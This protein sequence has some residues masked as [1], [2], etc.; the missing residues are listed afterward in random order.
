MCGISDQDLA[1]TTCIQNGDFNLTTN[2]FFGS[3]SI[4]SVVLDGSVNADVSINKFTLKQYY[5][6]SGKAL[7]LRNQDTNYFEL[8]NQVQGT[9]AGGYGIYCSA[10]GADTRYADSSGGTASMS[11]FYMGQG[12]FYLEGLEVAN[13]TAGSYLVINHF[14]LGSN[15]PLANAYIGKSARL[16]CKKRFQHKTSFYV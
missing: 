5:S 14:D 1:G 2:S 6:G 3:Q 11:N 4:H 10:Q 16:E 13:A 9:M 8:V 15:V 12:P 7:W